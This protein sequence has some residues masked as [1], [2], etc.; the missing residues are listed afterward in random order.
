MRQAPSIDGSQELCYWAKCSSHNRLSRLSTE[1]LKWVLISWLLCTWLRFLYLIVLILI[2]TVA[3]GI[4][5]SLC[6]VW[7]ETYQ[8]ALQII[9]NIFD[10]KVWRI[11][12]L[13]GL[14]HP[15]SS[16][17]YVQIGRSIAFYTVS[18]LSRDSCER[19]FISQ[20]M[21]LSLSS[22]WH[23][24]AFLCVFLVSFSS[25]WNPRYFNSFRLVNECCEI[26]LVER[27]LIVWWMLPVRTW[28]DLI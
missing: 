3:Y 12:V 5:K 6:K 17:P 11:L 25:R 24:L 27:Y 9:L 19:V 23:R 18:L 26:L 14:L 22:S 15:H 8:G 21:F 2:T 7:L 4:S 10:W 28:L 16:T 13:D 20:L 1:R